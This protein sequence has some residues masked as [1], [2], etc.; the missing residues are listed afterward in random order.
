MN[1]C[2]LLFAVLLCLSGCRQKDFREVSFALPGLAPIAGNAGLMNEA[3]RQLK[4]AF[5]RYERHVDPATGKTTQTLPM[6]GIELDSVRLSAD[7]AG[8]VRL[9][10][11]FDSLQAAEMNVIRLLDTTSVTNL[12]L[13]EGERA[14]SLRTGVAYPELKKDSPAGYIN[15]RKDEID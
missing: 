7:E 3:E 14:V 11:K 6:S 12:V 5:E 13:N 10:V 15:A 2:T 4:A 1:K 8:T 9:T